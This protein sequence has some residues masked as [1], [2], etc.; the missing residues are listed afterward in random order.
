MYQ[1]YKDSCSGYMM[2]LE[3]D[4]GR[5]YQPHQRITPCSH[6]SNSLTGCSI[7]AEIETNQFSLDVLWIVDLS[8]NK[9]EIFFVGNASC[10]VSQDGEIFSKLDLS[11][12]IWCD[13]APHS[14]NYFILD[15]LWTIGGISAWCH[16][17]QCKSQQQLGSYFDHRKWWS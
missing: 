2:V 9:R 1:Q 12:G 4:L 14:L 15:C 13:K 11:W 3:T 5:V 17:F 7:F 8:Q 6:S 10:F 16:H